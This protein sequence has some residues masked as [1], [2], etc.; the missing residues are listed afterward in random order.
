MMK[1]M[2]NVV[3]CPLDG[4]SNKV[5]VVATHS[6]TCLCYK[7]SL[8]ASLFSP[9]L[10]LCFSFSFGLVVCSVCSFVR[11]VRLFICKLVYSFVR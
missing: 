3:G 1:G 6:R 10:P 4:Q 9:L 7:L 8:L 11:F 2:W 5:R